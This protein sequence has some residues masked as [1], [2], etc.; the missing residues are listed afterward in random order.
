MKEII[1]VYT[2]KIVLLIFHEKDLLIESKVFLPNG[3]SYRE[4][5]ECESASAFRLMLSLVAFSS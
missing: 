1:S 3:I 5:F 4:T 2:D